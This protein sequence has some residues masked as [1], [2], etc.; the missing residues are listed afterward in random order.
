MKRWT[1]DIIGIGN[2][3]YI[4]FKKVLMRESKWGPVIELNEKIMEELAARAIIEF[5][6]S[7]GE[8]GSLFKKNIGSFFSGLC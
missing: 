7:A 8:R 3:D 6:L 4:I 5:R 2:L 1:E